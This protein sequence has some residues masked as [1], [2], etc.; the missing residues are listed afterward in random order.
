VYCQLEALR[1]CLPSSVHNILDDLPETLDETY[2]RI[3]RDI[4]KAKQDHA[5]RLLQCLT[6]AIRPLHIEELAEVLA[7]DFDAAIQ[8]GIPKLNPDWRCVD[9]QQALLSTCSS[10]IAITDYGSSQ[11]IQFSHF[12]VKE[13]LTSDR[14]ARSKGDVS[15]Y[16]IVLEPSHTVIAQAC[17]GVLLRLD[18]YV[19]WDDARDIPL[20]AYAARYWVEH[21]RFENVSSHVQAAME[22]LFDADKPHFL[23]WLRMNDM[24]EFWTRFTPEGSLP[25]AQPLYYAAMC[26]LYELVKHLTR[27]N[28]RHVNDKGGQK[29]TP[30]A[31]ALYGHHFHVADFLCQHGADVHIRGHWERTLLHAASLGGLVEV[32]R[33]LLHHGADV[34][35]RQDGLWTPLH[36]ATFRG[37]PEVVQV[38]LENN[39]D[40]NSPGESGEVALHLV[41]S[42]HKPFNQLDIMRMLLDHGA[43]PN[44]RDNQGS[45]PLH[46]SSYR[47]GDDPT[48]SIPGTIEGIRLML[49]YG[50]NIDAKNNMGETPLQVAL[51][52]EH[53][54]V[55]ESLSGHGAGLQ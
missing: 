49:E 32:V 31:A 15:R 12:T 28:P 11:L 40:P 34:D 44:A 23:A 42:P 29:V 30:L 21:A 13:F 20:A 51:A 41:A 38:L 46:H 22:R 50:A 53:Q 1:H 47:R 2:E 55:A 8:N 33:W 36:L 10:L 43:D 7:V 17:L 35:A 25:R 54:Q 14:L 19:S 27:R 52:N 5:H 24:D 18:D 9:Q 48:L 6:V 16:H 3:L 45:T 39:A 4:V 37:S 26:G